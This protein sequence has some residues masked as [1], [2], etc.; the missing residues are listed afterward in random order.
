MKKNFTPEK[1]M[2][3]KR[4][5]VSYIIREVLRGAN[6]EVR[7]TSRRPFFANHFLRILKSDDTLASV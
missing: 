3:E 6:S 1:I 5:F 4:N 7:K 2:V